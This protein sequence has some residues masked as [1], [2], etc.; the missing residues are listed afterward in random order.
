MEFNQA[1][2]EGWTDPNTFNLVSKAIKI[3]GKKENSDKIKK[4]IKKN[5][6]NQPEKLKDEHLDACIQALKN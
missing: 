6:A 3:L 4:Y 5:L 1:I 2:N